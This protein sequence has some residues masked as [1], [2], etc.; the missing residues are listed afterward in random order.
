MFS[1]SERELVVVLSYFDFVF[2][3]TNVCHTNA[4]VVTVASWIVW[5]VRQHRQEGKGFVYQYS[6]MFPRWTARRYH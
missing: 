1:V 2:C 3:H 5:L 6:C 4:D